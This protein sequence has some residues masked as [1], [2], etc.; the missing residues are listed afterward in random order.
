MAGSVYA[1]AASGLVVTYTTSGIFNFAH[2]AVG[3]LAAFTYWQLRVDW[4]WPAPIALISVLFILAPLFGAFLQRVIMSGL[5]GT[6]EIVARRRDRRRDAVRDRARDWVWNPTTRR[7]RSRS[8]SATPRRSIGDKLGIGSVPITYHELIALGRRH[9][10]RGRACASSSTGAAPGVAMRA[11]VDDQPL[12][13]LNGG[14][15]DRASL[16]LV[17][18]RLL[19]RRARRHP[20]HADPGRLAQRQPA[21]AARHQRVRRRDVRPPAQPSADVR[22]RARPRPRSTATS[23]STSRTTGRGRPTSASRS[24]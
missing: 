14:R 20:D 3:M 2:G 23:T 17:G 24:R 1:I 16:L 18:H 15:P 13:Q 9:R 6:S 8:S 22:R 4:G 12:L 5:Q 21:H 11:V 7:V 10:D 19:A